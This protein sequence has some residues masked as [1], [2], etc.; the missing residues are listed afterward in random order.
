[1]T[2]VYLDDIT[3]DTTTDV[4]AAYS[5][6]PWKTV[7]RTIAGKSVEITIIIKADVFAGAQITN[8]TDNGRKK[9][10]QEVKNLFAATT[11]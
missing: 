5:E 8:L 4:S 2:Q 11:V 7:T 10:V 9:V 3:G 6:W 1:M